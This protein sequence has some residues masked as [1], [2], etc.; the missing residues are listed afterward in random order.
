MQKAGFDA[1]LVGGAVR[2]LMINRP[3]YDW[4]ITTNAT[5]EQSQ[6]LFKGSF[7][8]NAYGTVGLPW[9]ALN[10]WMRQTGWLVDSLT[11]EEFEDQVMDITTY[12]SESGYSD[13]RRPDRVEW[14]QSLKEDLARRDF[15]LNAAALG[16]SRGDLTAVLA[17]AQKNP[18]QI[19]TAEVVDPYGGMEDLKAGLIRAVRDP[20]ERF[21]EDALRMMRGIRLGA[22][23]GMTLETE[24]LKAVQ[25]QAKLISQ[26][27]WERISQE[28]LKILA[29]DY[30]A[31][32]VK[33][34]YTSG[35]LTYLIPELIAMRGV[36]QGGHH[37]LDVWD[38]SLEAL[39]A[40]PSRDPIVRLATLLHD[41]GKPK[42]YREQGPRGVTFY[43]HEVVGARMAR[44]IGKR[45]RLPQKE[46]ERLFILVRWH[47][48]TYNPEM[49]DAAIRRFIR[50]VGLQNMN[51]M[52]NLR[53]GDRKGGG[54]QATSWRLRELQER[55][56]EQLYEPLSLKDM[57]VDG[58]TVMKELKLE[59]GPE[60]GRILNQLFEEVLDDSD[61]NTV[62]YLTGRMKELA[63]AAGQ[64]IPKQ[65]QGGGDEG[66]GVSAGD[67]TDK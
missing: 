2:D 33:L 47:M 23:L 64:P 59:P 38:H 45:L 11:L 3:T 60:V 6:A 4:D 67:G 10:S 25:S 26:I 27:A 36:K 65:K 7:Y 44:D 49:T 56:G 17:F 39:K 54:S 41:V 48:F 22:Q 58:Q 29:S 13:R 19:L 15:T 28:F 40:C 52:I 46:V 16:V 57:A 30:P 24:T 37:R 1:Y 43:A 21:A 61:K 34:L 55:I 20:M 51:D 32:G 62:E 50:R 31:D 5:P 53:V 42:T 8:D 12:R 9:P 14:G 66:A 63:A 35:L 18:S